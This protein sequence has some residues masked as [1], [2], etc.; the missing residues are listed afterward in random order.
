MSN[1]S[2]IK[3]RSA[4]MIYRWRMNDQDLCILTYS[5]NALIFH[6]ML[7]MYCPLEKSFYYAH[8]A[9]TVTIFPEDNIYS[10]K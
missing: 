9:I 1:I 10:F 5:N 7:C 3:H 4:K 6:T 2:L 8:M